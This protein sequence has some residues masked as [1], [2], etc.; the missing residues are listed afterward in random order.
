MKVLNKVSRKDWK[1]VPVDPDEN[2]DPEHNKRVV[3]ESIAKHEAKIKAVQKELAQNIKERSEAATMYLKNIEQ[4]KGESNIDKYFGSK[5]LAKL[6]AEN[7]QL[8]MRNLQNASKE[9]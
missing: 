6:K 7:P 8:R 4:G 5:I 3:E 9:S 2:F 1:F